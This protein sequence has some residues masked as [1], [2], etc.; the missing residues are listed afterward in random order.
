MLQLQSIDVLLR[1]LLLR[2]LRKEMEMM[3]HLLFLALIF[4]AINSAVAHAQDDIWQAG[5]ALRVIT[6][7]EPMWLGGYAARK[8]PSQGKLHDLYAKAVAFEDNS[9]ERAVLVTIDLIGISREIRLAV[10]QAVAKEFQLPAASLVINASHTHCGAELRWKKSSMYQLPKREI[11]KIK[12]YGDRLKRELTEL[13]GEALADLRPANVGY[14]HGRAGFAMN[15]RLPQGAQFVNRPY[16]DGPVDHDVPVLAISAPDRNLRGLVFGYACHN[17]TLGIQKFNG[18]YAG[19][20]QQYLQ[21]AH[22]GVIAMFVAGC[23]GDQNPQPRRTIELAKQH[24]RALANA[25]EAAI[26]SPIQPL[27]GTI[28]TAQEI[29]PLKFSPPPTRTELTLQ[30]ENGNVYEKRHAR[31]L[32]EQLDSEGKLPSTY[33]YPIHVWRLG[34]QL[35]FTALAG[36]PVVDY[37]LRL[38]RELTTS[39]VWVAGYSNDVFAYIPTRRILLEGGYEG[40]GAMTYTTLPGPWAPSVEKDVVD[41]VH[42]L[43]AQTV[44]DTKD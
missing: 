14:T 20:A 21:Q 11:Q 43:V 30:V 44:L 36:E 27:A 7:I 5:L 35:L 31:Q 37:S 26:I 2:V 28:R 1:K 3:K 13:V 38:K 41:A 10:E 25:V 34:N 33:P 42:R 8:E 22:R 24:G 16:A 12:A 32:L 23:G 4:V 39:H 19:F 6:P 18:D 40:G 17:T 15:R 29:V 9:G